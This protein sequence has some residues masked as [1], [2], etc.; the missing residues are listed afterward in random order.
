MPRYRSKVLNSGLFS[1]AYILANPLMPSDFN[2]WWVWSLLSR[3]PH[4]FQDYPR[5]WILN[6]YLVL[7]I[8][9]NSIEFIF[10]NFHLFETSQLSSNFNHSPFYINFSLEVGPFQVYLLRRYGRFFLLISRLKLEYITHLDSRHH[11]TSQS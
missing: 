6:R 1:L 7:L 10:F 9:S 4:R 8:Y 11:I 3:L 2:Q 5:N